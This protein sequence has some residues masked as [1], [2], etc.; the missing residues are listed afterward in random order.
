MTQPFDIRV[1]KGAGRPHRTS[2][3]LDRLRE[4]QGPTT[5]RVVVQAN[6]PRGQSRPS[7]LEYQR[8]GSYMID[9]RT[10]EAVQHV[11]ACLK[12]LMRD[13]DHTSKTEARGT[14]ATSR[15]GTN[16]PDAVDEME[17]FQRRLREITS[18]PEPPAARI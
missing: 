9:C 8:I 1:R 4:R 18:T 3:S 5:L 10:P 17:R 13:L 7:R 12:S 14:P 11:R 2:L 16:L 15:P 6:L